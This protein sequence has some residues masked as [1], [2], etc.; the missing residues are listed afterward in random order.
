MHSI[1]SREAIPTLSSTS[2]APRQK[3]VCVIPFRRDFLL[4]YINMEPTPLEI[5]ES[6]DMLRVLEYGLSVRMIPTK[7][8]T[9]AVDTMEDLV[10]V[11]K[12]M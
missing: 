2:Y 12:I 8:Q 3:Q 4:D 7:Y 6:I 9:H 1:F 10:K 5:V 11:E